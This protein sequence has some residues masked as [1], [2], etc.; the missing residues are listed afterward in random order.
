[1]MR[2]FDMRIAVTILEAFAKQ[3]DDVRS[4]QS[5][6]PYGS[7]SSGLVPSSQLARCPSL[8]R[9]TVV[10]ISRAMSQ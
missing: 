7:S 6:F 4:E 2:V 3:D 10:D 1:M 5:V 9:C 8:A